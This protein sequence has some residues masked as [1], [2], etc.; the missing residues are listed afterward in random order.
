MKE[1]FGVNFGFLWEDR[2]QSADEH[3]KCYECE[4]FEKCF[5]VALIR[6]LQAIKL[7]IRHGVR[8]IRN[9]LGGS[10]SEFPFG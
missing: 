8:G 9:S 10:H 7:E 1:C 5:K 3:K 4:D 6:S 2:V